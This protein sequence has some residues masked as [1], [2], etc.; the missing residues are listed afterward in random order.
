MDGAHK[1]CPSCGL[2]RPLDDLQC[3]GCGHGF[4]TR[5]PR[6]VNQT[7]AFQSLPPSVVGPHRDNLTQKLKRMGPGKILGAFASIGFSWWL[8][9]SVFALKQTYE[10]R[11]SPSKMTAFEMASC[12]D[13]NMPLRELDSYIGQPYTRINESSV[14]IWNIYAGKDLDLAV[15]ECNG[16]VQRWKVQAPPRN[17]RRYIEKQPL[18]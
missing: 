8:A 4:R 17:D 16:R 12:C 9:S 13:Y 10:E 15:L 5:F 14:A 3:P 2:C 1:I 7:T 18:R 6:P 11:P